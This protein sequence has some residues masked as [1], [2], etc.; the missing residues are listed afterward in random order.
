MINYLEGSAQVIELLGHVG[1][2]S[3]AKWNCLSKTNFPEDDEV[4]SDSAANKAT[5]VDSGCAF[6]LVFAPN[7]FLTS[8]QIRIKNGSHQEFRNML[9]SLSWLVVPKKVYQDFYDHSSF[10]L[11]PG[12]F[13]ELFSHMNPV[14]RVLL[15]LLLLL[16]L[17]PNSLVSHLQFEACCV[18]EDQEL[19]G[20]AF[21]SSFFF[22]IT[23]NG[24]CYFTS[25]HWPLY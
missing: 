13:W 23:K 7:L 11:E 3:A 25:T 1:L 4:C 18:S 20:W 22:P 14:P 19:L 6:L 10:I 24:T 15:M 12:W 16:F 2:C 5:A 9:F 8:I 21:F 17:L